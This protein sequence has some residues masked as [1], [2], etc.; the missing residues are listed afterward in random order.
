M[1]YV[2]PIGGAENAPY[3]DGDASTGTPGS[4]V[5]AKAI[6]GP[7]REIMAVIAAAGLTPDSE[8]LNQL[9]DAIKKLAPGKAFGEPFF[10]LGET[11]P[12]NALFFARQTMLR[13]DYPELWA[14][15]NESGRNIDII[16][17]AEYL[18]GRHGFWSAGD[19][20]TTFRA[21]DP[22]ALVLRI[23]DNGAGI[24]AGRVAGSYQ[25]DAIK[26]H[27]IS[28]LSAGNFGATSNATTVPL[29]SNQ[30][31]GMAGVRDGVQ[32][33]VTYVE[34]SVSGST[35]APYAKYEG[36]AET[37]SKSIAWPLAFYYK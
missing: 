18:A 21:P 32:T 6:E 33:D 25:E 27:V 37:R 4:V 22:R 1:E 34:H 19:G 11:P 29:T 2:Q 17:D 16:S 23:W 31:E 26:S 3:V 15:L 7:Q 14:S 9:L 12:V 24:D 10:H 36:E 35:P 30:S 13:A 28:L 20:S 5:P 8:N